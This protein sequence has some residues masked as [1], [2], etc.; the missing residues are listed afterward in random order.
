M[1]ASTKFGS[2]QRAW[3]VDIRADTPLDRPPKCRAKPI[4]AA[5]YYRQQ[6][7]HADCSV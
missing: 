2:K 1:E 3:H 5:Q 7:H 6:S 4:L